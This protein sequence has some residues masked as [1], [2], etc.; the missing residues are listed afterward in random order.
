MGWMIMAGVLWLFAETAQAQVLAVWDRVSGDVSAAQPSGDV[1]HYD[2]YLC[3]ESGCDTEVYKKFAAVPQ[4][5]PPV[6]PATKAEVS[7]KLPGRTVGKIKIRAVDKAGNQS[8]DSN[9]L[10]FDTRPPPAPVVGGR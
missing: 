8:P 1:D 9:V 10:G 4:P 6:A 3:V 5:G 2:V 7:W